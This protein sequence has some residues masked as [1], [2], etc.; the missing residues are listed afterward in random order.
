[1]VQISRIGAL[2]RQPLMGCL[3]MRNYNIA[4]NGH[5]LIYSHIDDA[6][7]I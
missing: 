4:I 3:S 1:M 7:Q 2:T 6:K 5:F